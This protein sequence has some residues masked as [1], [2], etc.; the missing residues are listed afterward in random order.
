MT[1]AK[2]KTGQPIKRGSVPSSAFALEPGKIRNWLLLIGM[3]GAITVVIF[4]LPDRVDKLEA[5]A[6]ETEKINAKQ[7][8]I[9]ERLTTLQETYVQQAF[10]IPE[11]PEPPEP[12][13]REFDPYI[14]I[15]Y[16]DN[17]RQCCDFKKYKCEA[18]VSW[19][20]C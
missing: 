18:E 2:N 3:I 16:R 5:R 15:R 19:I 8:L 12:E 14:I 9:L 6:G 1:L 17:K 20:K 11:P 7:D 10:R 4:T 13:Y